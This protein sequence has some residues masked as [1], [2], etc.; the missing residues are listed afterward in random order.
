MTQ[1][2]AKASEGHEQHLAHY[3]DGIKTRTKIT[4]V[5]NHLKGQGRLDKNDPHLPEEV[6][7]ALAAETEAEM[8]AEQGKAGSEGGDELLPQLSE[9]EGVAPDVLYNEGMLAHCLLGS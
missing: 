7:Q 9:G 1:T 3:V 8:E 6:R 2:L 5:I 4:N